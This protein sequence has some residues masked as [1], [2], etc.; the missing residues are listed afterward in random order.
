MSLN[1]WLSFDSYKEEHS[2]QFKGRDEDIENL[3]RLVSR[4]D[5]SVIYAES[6]IGKSSLINAGLN[7]LLRSGLFLPVPVLLREEKAQCD[8]LKKEVEYFF[9]LFTVQH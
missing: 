2:R 6:G 3:Y 7:P 1:P 5:I 4:A 8:V 9:Q